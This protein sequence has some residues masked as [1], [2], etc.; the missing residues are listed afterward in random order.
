MNA[1]IEF[2][3]I[4]AEICLGTTAF[5]AIIATLRQTLGESLTGYQYLITRYF[6]DVGLTL[7]FISIAGIA[8]YAIGQSN[9]LAWQVIAWSQVVSGIFYTP[10][11]FA[12]RRKVT[13]PSSKTALLV[14]FLSL[15]SWLNV[16]LVLSGLSELPLP[17][18]AMFYFVSTFA[19]LILVFVIFIGSFMNITESTI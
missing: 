19:G 4:F 10:Y 2:L 6:I 16:M 3:T 13:A 14:S 15:A 12:K 17:T 9:S 5:F 18:A 1:D 8:A 7:V 11:Y